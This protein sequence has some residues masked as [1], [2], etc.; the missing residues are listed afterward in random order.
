MNC[1]EA[2]DVMGE[3]IEGTLPDAQRAGLDGHLDECRP[4]RVYM[5]QLVL[6][7]Q[8]LGRLRAPDAPPAGREELLRRYR[9]VF[10]PGGPPDPDR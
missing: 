8:A 4:C 5:E 2:I 9:G 3:A 7:R 1:Y 10:G 6:T